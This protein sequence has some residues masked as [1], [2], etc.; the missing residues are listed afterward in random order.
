MKDGRR[1]LF[2]HRCYVVCREDCWLKD[3]VVVGVSE[4]IN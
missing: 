1:Q 4:A 3:H 2:V